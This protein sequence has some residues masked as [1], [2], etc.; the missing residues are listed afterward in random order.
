VNSKTLVILARAALAVG[1]ADHEDGIADVG[2]AARDLA[3]RNTADVVAPIE[4][5][6]E[7]VEG[8]LGFANGGGR[9]R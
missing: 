1:V 7:H 9:G 8:S 4:L 2:G 6:T 5:E 3:D